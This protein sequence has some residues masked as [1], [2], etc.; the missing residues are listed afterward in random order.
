[1]SLNIALLRYLTA[2]TALNGG[3]HGNAA[4]PPVVGVVIP[5]CRRRGE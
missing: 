5:D 4:A 2:S 1:M 3:R